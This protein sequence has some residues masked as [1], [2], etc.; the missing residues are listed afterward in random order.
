MEG[1]FLNFFILLKPR[2]LKN[3]VIIALSAEGSCHESKELTNAWLMWSCCSVAN[4]LAVG[5]A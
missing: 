3:K 5:S 4:R 2:Y 1:F